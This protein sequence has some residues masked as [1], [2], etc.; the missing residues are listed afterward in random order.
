MTDT[1]STTLPAWVGEIEERAAKATPG[2]WESDAGLPYGVRP[3]IVGAGSLIAEVGNAV[4]DQDR[5]E[6]DAAFIAA[7]REDVPRLLAL[8]REQ[9]AEID[10]LR[11]REAHFAQ[12]LGVA[13]GG[14]YRAD[15]EAPLTRILAERDSLRARVEELEGAQGWKPIETAPVGKIVDLWCIYGDEIAPTWE[16]GHVVGQIKRSCHKSAEYGWFGNHSNDGVPSG[17]AP[18]PIPV[19]WR[20][21]IPPCPVDLIAAALQKEQADD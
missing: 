10:R 20:E 16:T 19:A 21:P 15:W 5:W 18:D 11:R 9:A 4:L 7:S 8:V 6:A 14:Q 2:P 17:D 1:P 3:R 12:V 13:D